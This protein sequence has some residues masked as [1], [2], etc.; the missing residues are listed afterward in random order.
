MRHAEVA[1]QLGG[2][3]GAGSLTYRVP[4]DLPV[5]PGD[6]VLVPLLK[7]LLPGVV[8]AVAGATP[9]FPTRP[10]EDRLA[11]DAF[12]GPLQLTLAR[13]I[14]AHYRASLFD[15]LALFLPPGLTAKLL[16]AARDGRL[17]VPTADPVPTEPPTLPPT[18]PGPPLTIA[19][20]A[21]ARR[22]CAAIEGRQHQAFLLHG[23]TGSGKTHV[24]LAAVA[25]ALT[26]GRQAI[27]LVSEIALTPT[28]IARFE[29]RFPGRVAVLHSKLAPAEHRRAWDRVRR[30]EAD[31]VIGTRSALFAPVRRPG[32]VILDEEHEWTY[33]QEA[34]PRYHAREVA[35]WWGQL[36]RAP[37][38]LGSATPDVE[39]YYRAERGRYTLLTL[40]A[41]FPRGGAAGETRA[42]PPVEVVDLRA[43]LRRGNTSIF[44]EALATALHETLDRGEQALLFLNRRGSA[45]CVSCRD[46]GHV[47]A[48]RRCDVPLV[49]HRVDE[50]LV[51]HRCNRRRPAPTRC[52][53]CGGARIRYFGLGTQRVEAEMRAQFPT[54]RVL[55]W[56]RDVTTRRDVHSKLWRAFEAGEADVLVGTQ[57]IAKALDF[58]RVTLVGVVLADVGLFLPDPRAGERAFQLV[59][60]M[61]G[62]TGRG[63]L[64]G[65]AIV[66]T[67]VP[68]H[69]A[70]RAAAGHD[71]A[72]FYRREIAF[73]RAH[74][75]P[76]LGRLVR[77][78]Y[79]GSGEE[80]CV[81]EA[82]KVRRV[83][84][85]ELRR[86]GIADI[87]AL[88]PAPCY[89]R[90][91]RGRERWQIVL[92]GDRFA[93][94]LD[95]VTL[96]PGWAIDVDP[97]N[98]L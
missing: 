62:R 63:P 10:V 2:R 79:T 35:L 22:I 89:V 51:C 16:R 80:R 9:D 56:D 87:E 46:C 30:G 64:G 18:L 21:A 48:C 78:V 71:F 69:Y 82:A 59:S 58:P 47:L 50:M 15:C 24:Y 98:L 11:D 97:V 27:V 23:V 34:S 3:G 38:V 61:A 26:L 6:L 83:L 5:R 86:Q 95:R 43:E 12:L 73:R 96:P 7:R 60:Q 52:P 53:S 76:P 72:A 4:D 68:E 28:T 33:K 31:V 67:Y 42:L 17:R 40:P 32:L 37:V 39:S 19:Q 54:A 92:R 44:S 66:Q 25:Q 41:R 36:A 93:R 88:G 65:R 55:R 49:Y 77:L 90:R 13:W 84:D 57:M 14:A 75:Y 85:D 81:R 8:V 20:E 91:V 45:T 29:E 74:G 94:V 1:L 70:I